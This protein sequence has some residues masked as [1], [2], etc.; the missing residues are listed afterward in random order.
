M[1]KESGLS[2][3]EFL[4][5]GAAAA[6][7]SIAGKGLP[8]VRLKVPPSGTVRREALLR[9]RIGSAFARRYG[10]EPAITSLTASGGAR[11]ERVT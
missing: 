1:K 6:G 3:R 7:V 11:P 8:G 2:R 4:E 10:R 5:V 9:R